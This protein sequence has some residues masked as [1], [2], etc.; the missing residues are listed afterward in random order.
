MMKKIINQKAQAVMEY[1]L[2]FTL[3]LAAVLASNFLGRV[4]GAFENYYNTAQN[5]IAP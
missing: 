5:E 2:I 1:F 4:K 3:V